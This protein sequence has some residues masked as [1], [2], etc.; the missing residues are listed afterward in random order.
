MR[1]SRTAPRRSLAILIALA[2]PA[3]GAVPIALAAGDSKADS[4]GAASAS[5]SGKRNDPKNQTAISKFMETCVAGNAQYA[6]RDFQGAIA[7]YRE[8]IKL[9]PKN[10][11]G[12]YLL[13]EAQLAANNLPE[14]EASWNQAALVSDAA[15]PRLRARVLFVVADV[16]ERQKKWDE[17]KTAWANY[18]EWC[19][20]F[21]DAGVG[22]PASGASRVQALDT[23]T[24]LNAESDK[25]KQRIRETADGGVFTTVAPGAS[26]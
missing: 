5:A 18:N 24:K 4:K 26:K 21:A 6:A 14:A 10:P 11:L 23:M 8:A 13:G 3:I 22:F 17:A 7:T 2:A 12:H 25:V 19:G 15:D 1:S 9:D 16:K 20:R